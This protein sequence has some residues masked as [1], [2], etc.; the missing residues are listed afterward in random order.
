MGKVSIVMGSNNDFEIMKEAIAILRDANVETEVK[1]M[2]IHKSPG[3]TIEYAKNL[4]KNGIEVIIAGAGGAFHLA[5]VISGLTSIPVIAV[6]LPVTSLS[7][8]D[9]LLSSVQMPSGVPVAVMSIGKWGARNAALFAIR[10]LSMRDKKL[11]KFLS[12]YKSNLA[13]EIEDKERKVKEWNKK[14]P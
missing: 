8:L 9:S 4:E 1:V 11:K 10:I 3:K 7:G 6:P 12:K 14:K 13:E 5:G 2:S